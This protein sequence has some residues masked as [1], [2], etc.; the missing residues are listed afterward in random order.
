MQNDNI[1]RTPRTLVSPQKPPEGSVHYSPSPI[2]SGPL[3]YRPTYRACH[4]LSWQRYSYIT[5]NICC[6]ILCMS[7]YP[8][9]FLEIG[10][11]A[12]SQMK[13]SSYASGQQKYWNQQRAFWLVHV[14]WRSPPGGRK[15]CHHS[16]RDRAVLHYSLQRH[17]GYHGLLS[18][19]NN[20]FRKG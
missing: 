11:V 10:S 12:V 16:H 6:C 5:V 7:C 19:E 13:Q 20:Y 4:P 1:H 8:H 2:Q 17:T 9:M 18:K 15:F 14:C 3:S